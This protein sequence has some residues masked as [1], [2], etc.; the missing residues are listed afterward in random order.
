MLNS[1]LKYTRKLGI[2]LGVIVEW[3]LVMRRKSVMYAVDVV[4][5][6]AAEREKATNVGIHSLIPRRN[7]VEEQVARSG[8]LR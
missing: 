2:D 8:T 3:L 6:A 4:L 5:N 7:N 1:E